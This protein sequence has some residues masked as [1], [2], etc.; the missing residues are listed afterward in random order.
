MEVGAVVQSPVVPAGAQ[1]RRESGI[2]GCQHHR[3]VEPR[4]RIVGCLVT[5]FLDQ[6]RL[7][8]GSSRGVSPCDDVSRDVDCAA[9]GG[10][11]GALGLRQSLKEISLRL[12]LRSESAAAVPGADDGGRPIV[13][14]QEFSE[15]RD[16]RA[17][18]ERVSGP[19]E[20]NIGVS[21]LADHLGQA[22]SSQIGH[23]PSTG[24]P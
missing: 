20:S 16:G 1:D 4:Q 14:N 13:P 8:P 5:K 11:A 9:V 21:L 2:V 15:V 6:A 12:V 3:S 17:E 24:E 7:L 19:P 18:D 22:E 10:Q 23:Q